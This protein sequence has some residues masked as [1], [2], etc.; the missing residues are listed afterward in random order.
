MSERNGQHLSAAETILRENLKLTT[1]HRVARMIAALRLAEEIRR[2]R[3]A[4]RPH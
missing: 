2:S 4:P 3:S 1:G